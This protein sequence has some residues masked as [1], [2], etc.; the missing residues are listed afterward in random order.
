[1][2]RK[3]LCIGNAAYPGEAALQNPVNDAVAVGERLACLGFEGQVC[4]DSTNHGMH[5]AIKEFSSEL[6]DSD[7]GLFFFAG[8][9]MQIDGENYLAAVD[10][11]FDTETVAKFSSQSLNMV[12]EVLEK[13][14]NSTSIIILDACR[15]NP[16]ERRWRSGPGRGLAPVYA[17][18]G[19]LV[20]YATSP[21]QVAFDGIGSNGSFTEAF[22]KH[23]SSQNITIEDLFKRVRNSLNAATSGKQISWEHTS[24]MGDFFFNP[25]I[26]SGKVTAYSRQALADGSFR[27]PSGSPLADV[28]A[29]LSSHDWYK[30]K[31]AMRSIS[32]IELNEC[33]KDELFVLGRNIYQAACGDAEYSRI[34]I[35]NLA[36][37]LRSY[38]EDTAFH[39]LNGMLYEI[40]FDSSGSFREK[41]KA[42][43]LDDVF[44]LDGDDDE[45]KASF[46]FI[47]SSLGAYEEQLFYVPSSGRPILVDI[48]MRKSLD[49]SLAVENVQ[50]EGRSILYSSDG[51]GTFAGA[52]ADSLC[53]R[54]REQF[55]Q[56]L[57]SKLAVP[58]R[59][60]TITYSQDV[61]A[62]ERIGVP[63]DYVVW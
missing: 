22:L 47:R 50:V 27:L 55:E 23:V 35:E 38:Q 49:D 5:D 28:I 6:T 30:Q 43:K 51:T 13:G 59:L 9:G 1:M 57:L 25:S 19:M 31:P 20:A 53:S 58:A 36:D 3:S 62:K 32:G 39:I 15:T 4:V 54:T 61:A 11:D 16:Y 29:G 44:L 48:L 7:V 21:G 8:H 10:T 46:E 34:Y 18:R 33:E 17:P 63:W 12:I 45:F 14:D 56:D 60:C 40:Y 26:L 41:K 52:S 24:L 42:G 37:R 2:I